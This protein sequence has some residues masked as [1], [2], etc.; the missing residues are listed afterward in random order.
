MQ[1]DL[2]DISLPLY[3]VRKYLCIKGDSIFD[4]HPRKLEDIVCSVFKDIGWNARATAYSGD[5]GID[6]ILDGPDGTTIG[7]QVTPKVFL[8][9]PVISG[10]AQ[11]KRLKT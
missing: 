1:L 11:N 10:R 7:I 8:W 3:E 2:S 4:V 9:R 5:R 6:V